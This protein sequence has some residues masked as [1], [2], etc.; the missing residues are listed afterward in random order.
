MTPNT[1]SIMS[2][3]NGDTIK[4]PERIIYLQ[5]IKI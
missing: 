1:Q 5:M 4:E 3:V 2:L